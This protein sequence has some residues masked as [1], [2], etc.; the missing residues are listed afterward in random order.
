MTAPKA[1]FAPGELVHHKR[2]DYRGVVVDVDP[3]FQGTDERSLRAI[4][5]A[6]MP[7]SPTL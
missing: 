7:R 6:L 4:A 5:P 2:F 1:K 3:V